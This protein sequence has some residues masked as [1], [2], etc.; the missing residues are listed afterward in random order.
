MDCAIEAALLLAAG[1]AMPADA[2]NGID[3]GIVAAAVPH[4]ERAIRDR[5]A[6]D[7]EQISWLWAGGSADDRKSAPDIR[8]EA[9][10]VARGGEATE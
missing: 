9:A 7:I 5:I 4:I 1:Y 2:R 10:R 3:R 8:A 6:A